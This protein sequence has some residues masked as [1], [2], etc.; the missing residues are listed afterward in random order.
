MPPVL[1][2]PPL[3]GLP[4]APESGAVAAGVVEPHAKKSDMEK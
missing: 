1:F 2:A 3:P 4:P